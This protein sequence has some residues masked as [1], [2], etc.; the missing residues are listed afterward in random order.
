MKFVY[1]FRS[2]IDSLNHTKKSISVVGIGDIG[3]KVINQCFEN[4][5]CGLDYHYVNHSEQ[6]KPS[7]IVTDD[8]LD[9]CASLQE[10]EGLQ[11]VIP[12]GDSIGNDTS[13][14]SLTD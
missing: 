6:T 13:I 8:V 2:G 12:D 3:R 14:F 11:F 5:L 7:C 1:E 4:E 10:D 9:D